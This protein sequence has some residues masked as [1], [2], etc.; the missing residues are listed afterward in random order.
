MKVVGTGAPRTI[1]VRVQPCEIAIWRDALR[2]RMIT[3]TDPRLRSMSP[4]ADDEP[5]HC[6]E[7]GSIARLL[8]RAHAP[9]PQG[10]PWVLTGPSWLLGDVIQT[11]TRAAVD[12]YAEAWRT[13]EEVPDALNADRL[14]VALDA[15][16][17]C[18]A[19]AIAFARVQ[20]DATA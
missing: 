2:R 1:T 4:A 15:A 19:T 16:S 17:A 12:R 20:N 11:V 14:R 10:Q 7:A 18:T 3:A 9:V 6:H 8:E 13:F 5:T